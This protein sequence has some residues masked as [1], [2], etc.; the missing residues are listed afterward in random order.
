MS[1]SYLGAIRIPDMSEG[2][3]LMAVK[4]EVTKLK[5]TYDTF[6]NRLALNFGRVFALA[7]KP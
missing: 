3:Q 2:L 6:K 4:L 7:I 5:L 1:T